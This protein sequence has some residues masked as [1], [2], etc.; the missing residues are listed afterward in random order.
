MVD[1]DAGE[2]AADVARQDEGLEVVD[3]G[4][5]ELAGASH[6]RAEQPRELG[7]ALDHPVGRILA[8]G[9]GQHRL[10]G[11]AV[12]QPSQ[13][14]GDVGVGGGDRGVDEHVVRRARAG[15]ERQVVGPSEQPGGLDEERSCRRIGRVEVADHVAV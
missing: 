5:L 12:A 11:E 15:H 3:H 6:G 8:L 13:G 1:D 14:R 9:R 7:Q 4:P 10:G 2:A